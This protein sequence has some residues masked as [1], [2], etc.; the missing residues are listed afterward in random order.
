MPFFVWK[1][2]LARKRFVQPHAR[3][4]RLRSKLRHVSGA[5][6]V[7]ERCREQGWIIFFGAGVQ[8]GGN[9]LFRLEVV[10]RVVASKGF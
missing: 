9:V 5:R 10:R 7:P 8:I 6:D 4:T 3:E 2:T 1:A